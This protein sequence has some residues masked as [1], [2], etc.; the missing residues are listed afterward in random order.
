VRAAIGIVWVAVA[1]SA[2]VG[3]TKTENGARHQLDARTALRTTVSSRF[4]SSYVD[5]LFRREQTQAKHRLTAATVS[6]DDFLQAVES[7]DFPAAVLLDDSGRVLHVYPS[8]PELVGQD[9]TATSE[10]QYLRDAVS[11]HR[12]I[13]AVVPAATTG[14][15]IVAFALPFDTPA[16][17]RVFSG[18]FDLSTTPL[19]AF[20]HNATALQPNWA[21]I[22]DAGG[23]LVAS[24]ETPTPD[25]TTLHNLAPELSDAWKRGSSGVFHADGRQFK[26]TSHAVEGTSW[27]LVVAV[28]ADALYAP[29]AG[30]NL[31]L[32]GLA[33][34]LV[35]VT[36]VIGWLIAR[37]S[38]RTREAAAARDVALEATREKSMFL[39]NMSHEIRTPMNGVIGMTDLLLDTDLDAVQRDYAEIAQSSAHS[40]LSVVNDVLDFSKIEAGRLDIER[41]DFD[42]PAVVR[43]V[44]DMLRVTANLKGLELSSSIAGSVPASLRG[45]PT[46]LRQILTNLV[47]NAIKFTEHGSVHVSVTLVDP[48]THRTRFE[49]ID[50]GIGMS[51]E[52][53][54]TIFEPFTQAESSITRRYGG[55]GLGLTIT[56]RLALLMDGECGVV[57]REASGS[58]FW[59][60]LPLPPGVSTPRLSQSD[61]LVAST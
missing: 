44:V 49:V 3:V 20:L 22:V 31:V 46:R 23:G 45:D 60:E 54:A 5:E 1:L 48:I 29:L 17:R 4:V 14:T 9:L 16:G 42:M 39:A 41:V 47:G 27:R 32:R 18:G 59:V 38:R 53:A 37:L 26:Y 28:P 36:A 61:G 21:V 35:I 25:T 51:E 30:G 10:Y 7:M 33:I 34:A 43:G 13:S 19:T 55:T 2:V 57:T 40:L 11:G 56:R 12:S 52:M 58:T 6:E 24:N 15:P 8:K 50:T